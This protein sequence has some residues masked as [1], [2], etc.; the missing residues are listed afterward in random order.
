[1]NGPPISSRKK[2][3]KWTTELLRRHSTKPLSKYS[4]SFI[5]EPKVIKDILNALDTFPASTTLIEVGTGLGTLTYY[6]LRRSYR[7][8]SIELD[9]M[10]A[11][12]AY[13]I[14]V[15]KNLFLLNTDALY[16]DWPTGVLVSNTP[17]HISSYLL[18]KLARSNN[19]SG[20][21]LVLQKEVASRLIAKPGTKS[22]G[23][24]GIL[25]NILFDIEPGPVYPPSYF[26][27]SP[28]VS[29]RLVV[30][31][32]KA[33]YSRIHEILENI[34]RLLFSQ[35]RKLAIKVIKKRLAL[36]YEEIKE[37]G[38]GES[39]RIYQ[40]KPETLLRISEKILERSI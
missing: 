40:L 1:M 39:Q 24:L 13:N 10:L 32:R 18:V 36:S 23:R 12:I 35:R 9:P 38:V 21:V 8:V 29:A 34:T 25:L 4:Q 11:S 16:I 15:S 37:V 31:K 7:L 2:L 17:F 27:P 3:L 30:L 33:M 6:L 22:Y 19:V 20:A 28:E 5:I 26:Y 14:C